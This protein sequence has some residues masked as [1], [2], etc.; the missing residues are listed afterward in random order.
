MF[1]YI[2]KF[3]EVIS[4]HKK[5]Y[6][7]NCY[8]LYPSELN[9]NWK[10]NIKKNYYKNNVV[11][12]L[13]VGRLKIEKGI[14]SLIDIFSKL[15]TNIKLTIVGSGD[16]IKLNNGTSNI[17]IKNFVRNESKLIKL[18][19][20]SNIFILPSYT[21]AYPKVINEALSSMRPV[22][23]FNEIKDVIDNR[24]GVFS[25]RRNVNELLKSIDFIKKNNNLIFLRMKKNKLYERLD[26]LKSLE[27]IIGHE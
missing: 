16:S 26:F 6:K 27:E 8:I 10:K 13:Y 7:K 21:E 9:L 19:D 22:I 25:I 5:L 24:Y 17:K 1:R 15:P 20:D 11:N 12:I 18:Y 4:C 23:I 3:S 2:I 14:Y